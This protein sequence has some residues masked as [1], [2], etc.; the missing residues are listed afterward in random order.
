MD[1]YETIQ[2]L[3]R[4]KE[5]IERAI[6]QLEELQASLDSAGV[7]PPLYQRRGRKWMG[8]EERRQV[9]ERMK[10]YWETRRR[11]AETHPRSE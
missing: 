7:H 6:A 5:K 4:E 9:S 10:K 11:S 3:K 8:P 2:Q 1:L